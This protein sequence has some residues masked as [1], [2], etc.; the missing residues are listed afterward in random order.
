[1]AEV[2]KFVGVS[3]MPD[4]EMKVRYANDAGR[5]KHLARVGHTDIN[6]IELEQAE[7]KEDCVSSLMDWVENNAD[8][9]CGEV[10][11]VVADEAEAMGFA[12][13]RC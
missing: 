5:V 11:Q 6:F 2:F 12:L 4:G 13:A 10:L 3:R 8:T 7:R 9:V 1:M